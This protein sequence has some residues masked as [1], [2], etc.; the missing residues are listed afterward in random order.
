LGVE[1]LSEFIHAV[2]RVEKLG[3]RWWLL[4][5][6]RVRAVGLLKVKSTLAECLGH[7]TSVITL[8]FGS[9]DAER[10]LVLGWVG[11]RFR[12]GKNNVFFLE[13][14]AKAP[15]LLLCTVEIHLDA[16]QTFLVLPF[17]LEGILGPLA[18]SSHFFLEESH[19]TGVLRPFRVGGITFE[20]GNL[21]LLVELLDSSLVFFLL[22]IVSADQQLQGLVKCIALILDF[23][24]SLCTERT[25]GTR[26]LPTAIAALD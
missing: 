19:F 13:K 22:L 17:L 15:S 24:L 18:Q 1:F 16:G 21:L 26:A 4:L 6:G 5:I 14:M 8:R 3:N 10:Q 12:T 7:A 23:L 2:G 20:V 11:R 25:T 9:G